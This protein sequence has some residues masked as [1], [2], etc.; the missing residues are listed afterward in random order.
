MLNVAP[1]E[2]RENIARANGYL[3]RNEVARALNTM[4]SALRQFAGVQLMRGP[5]A[6]LDIQISEFLTALMHHQAMQPLLDPHNTGKPKPIRYQQGKE[7]ALA[8]VL[9]GLAKIMVNEAESEIRRATEERV[10]RKK[11]LIETGTKLLSEGQLAKGRA[12]LKRVAEEFS[13]D[14]GIRVQLARIFLAAGQQMEAAEMFEESIEHEPREV[15][16]YSG[17]VTTWLEMRE[18]ERAEKVF[19]A[20]LRT[21]GG[22]P[23]TFG[24]MAK[25]YWDWH[26]RDKAEELAIR[27]LQGNKSQPE[28]MEVMAAL[29]QRQAH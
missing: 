13:E 18:Y 16:A 27:A 24:K 1:K 12:F 10:E 11:M 20:I 6:E 25:M 7:G 5:R 3:R 15:Q 17:A 19:Q 8:T 23:N 29:K 28:A 4:G 21:F 22:H 2:L 26:K 14:P 9:E